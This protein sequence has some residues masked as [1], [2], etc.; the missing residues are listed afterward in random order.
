MPAALCWA[1]SCPRCC[2]DG[3]VWSLAHPSFE[4]EKPS[5]GAWVAH[6]RVPRPHP[7]LERHFLACPKPQPR[8]HPLGD[9]H[10]G[11][12]GEGQLS[13]HPGRPLGLQTSPQL[14]PT[15]VRPQ[16]LPPAPP[17]PARGGDHTLPSA[18]QPPVGASPAALGWGPTLSAPHPLAL[19]SHAPFWHIPLGSGC[20][21]WHQ[22]LGT[23]YEGSLSRGLRAAEL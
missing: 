10:S 12:V 19:S 21:G 3:Q 20:G 18:V 15:V 2:P 11:A 6:A 9:G 13:K 22:A 5:H 8:T 16:C 14:W 4:G 7:G 1:G 23:R 17:A